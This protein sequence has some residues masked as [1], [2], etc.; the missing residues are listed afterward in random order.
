MSG[1]HRSAAPLLSQ[2]SRAL[3]VRQVRTVLAGEA[4]A[5]LEKSRRP[6]VGRGR[7]TR[8]R[9]VVGPGRRRPP[10][11]ENDNVHAPTQDYGDPGARSSARAFSAARADFCR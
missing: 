11:R 9:A 3:L 7:R 6:G 2:T 10:H 8:L 1:G 4:T 5:G